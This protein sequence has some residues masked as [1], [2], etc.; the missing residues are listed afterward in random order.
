CVSGWPCGWWLFGTP[1]PVPVARSGSF[2]G[3]GH[4]ED[5]T[6]VIPARDE[7]ARIGALLADLGPAIA[8]G[9]R[10][11]VVDDHSGDDTALVA[12]RVAGVEVVQ[13]AELPAGWTGKCW[14][15]HTGV[16]H[17][18]RNPRPEVEVESSGFRS[19]VFL[20]A[21]VRMDP[22]VLPS[23]VRHQ[24]LQGGLVSV[25]PWHATVR[26][27]EQLSALFN[28]LAVMGTGMGAAHGSTGAFGPVMVTT[29]EDYERVGGHAAVHSEVVEDLALAASYRTAGLPVELLL[30][31][32]E[33]R[34]RMYPTGLRALVEG[35]TKNFASGAAATA[36]WRL[37][38]TVLW[39]AAV[40]SSFVLAAESVAGARALWLGLVA[41]TLVVGQLWLMLRR[42]G[43]FGL[44][45]AAA[46]PVLLVAFLFVFARSVW[47]TRV[48]RR[49]RWR[50]RSIAVGARRG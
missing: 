2:P 27:L 25:Q 49:V 3:E 42:V 16:L 20:D 43:R 33:L 36:R 10:V 46:T 26:P 4:L 12:G 44:L 19:L 34:F 6:V 48:R 13:A 30:G 11:V 23:L 17:A 18:A 5:C 15:C 14:A 38:G 40:G 41:Y 24:R 39:I 32:A 31:G 7:G 50:G 37:V 35:W 1:R 9:L 22:P 21:D 28:L 47:L 45:T 29:P 8:R